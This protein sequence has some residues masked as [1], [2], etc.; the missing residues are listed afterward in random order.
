MT[1][2]TSREKIK[3]SGYSMPVPLK[4]ARKVQKYFPATYRVLDVYNL[5]SNKVQKRSQ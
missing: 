1:N 3:L 5:F 4:F 2:P